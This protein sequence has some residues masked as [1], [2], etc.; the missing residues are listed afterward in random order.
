MAE[1]IVAAALR[2]EVP[3]EWREKMYQGRRL[4]PDFMTVSAPPPARHHTLLHP[5][6]DLLGHGTGPE[7]QGFTTSTGRYVDRTEGLKIAIA[8]GQADPAN[9]RS[10]SG[11]S[12]LFSEDLW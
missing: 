6:F 8:A 10:G 3:D 2:I 7:D 5:C 1:T 9:R 12:H 11:S 4:Y